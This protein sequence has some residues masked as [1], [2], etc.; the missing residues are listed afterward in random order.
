[1]RLNVAEANDWRAL[2]FT[3]EFGQSPLLGIIHRRTSGPASRTNIER[4]NL[5]ILQKEERKQRQKTAD[6]RKEWRTKQSKHTQ[7]KVKDGEGEKR[8]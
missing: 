8:K 1:M 5:A 2:M 3:I 7:E 6:K 4:L